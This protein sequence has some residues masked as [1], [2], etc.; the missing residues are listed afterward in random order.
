MNYRETLLISIIIIMLFAAFIN[1]YLVLLLSFVASLCI[2]LYLIYRILA[3]GQSNRFFLLSSL[4][5]GG[6]ISGGFL[7]SAFYFL[8]LPGTNFSTLFQSSSLVVIDVRI[9]ALAAAYVFLFILFSALFSRFSFIRK[10]EDL[11]EQRILDRLRYVSLSTWS[12]TLFIVSLVLIAVSYGG[13]YSIKGL[14]TEFNSDQGSLPWWY[15]LVSFLISTLPI[16]ISQV[17]VHLKFPLSLPGFVG[18][19]GF[20]TGFYFSS[21]TGRFAVLAYLLLIPLAWIVIQKP[22]LSLAPRYLFSILM[23]LLVAF[24]LFPVINSFFAFINVARVDAGRYTNPL[25]FLSSYLDFIASSQSVDIAL[26]VSAENLT[27][28]PLVLWPLAASISMV[29][30]GENSGFLYFEDLFN[31][32]LNTLPRIIF[33]WKD[34]LVLQENLLYSS[35]PFALPWIDT[36]D[37]PYL[38]AFVSFGLFGVFVYP[39]AIGLVY[40]LFLRFMLVLRRFDG[41]FFASLAASSCLISFSILSYAELATTGLLRQF[42]VPAVI[43]LLGA[44]ACAP[45]VLIRSYKLR[46]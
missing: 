5:C 3:D 42:L 4:A 32:V 6:W 27:S 45:L 21:I 7:Q 8:R 39:L 43:G 16:L 34:S 2:S 18:I 9:Y 23:L 46:N 28:R 14:A 38:Y 29:L 22:R 1:S 13:F 40:W 12:P 26:S 24:A 11:F 36:A 30:E 20:L 19:V 37:S 31:S 15:I 33:P 35:F 44:L 41:L 17:F 25:L 10:A